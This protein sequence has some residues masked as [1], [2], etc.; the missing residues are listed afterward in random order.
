MATTARQESATYLQVI[1]SATHTAG[2]PIMIGNN[3]FGVPQATVV[4]GLPSNLQIGGVAALPK[5]SGAAAYSVGQKVL[6]DA[7]NNVV[8]DSGDFPAIGLCT[9]AATAASTSVEVKLNDLPKDVSGTLVI[10]SGGSTGTATVPG[11]L[12]GKNVIIQ[13]KSAVGAVAAAVPL[14][15]AAIASTTLTVTMVDKDNVATNASSN[16][17]VI[18]L[19]LA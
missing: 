3:L 8:V 16:V 5:T 18:Y 14:F 7:G 13:L 4:S 17:T 12:A 1:A 11:G 10:A 2:T 9:K 19:I 15:R 6:W